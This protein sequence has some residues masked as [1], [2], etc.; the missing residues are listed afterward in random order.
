M[1][2]VA[3]RRAIVVTI[4]APTFFRLP[5]RSITNTSARDS[6][7]AGALSSSR[8]GSV[9]RSAEEWA[10]IMR[11]FKSSIVELVSRPAAPEWD[12]DQ[13]YGVVDVPID[14]R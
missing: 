8:S 14:F 2:R 11:R 3:R 13:A 6:P 9:R 5:T 10:Q 7:V 12:R 4:H 1:R